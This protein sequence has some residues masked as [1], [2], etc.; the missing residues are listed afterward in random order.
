MGPEAHLHSSGWEQR[1]RLKRACDPDVIHTLTKL[2]QWGQRSHAS[3]YFHSP[4]WEQGRRLKRVCDQDDTHA[5]KKLAH[6]V[7]DVRKCPYD[8]ATQAGSSSGNSSVQV[9][10]TL[11]GGT[12]EAGPSDTYV[13]GHH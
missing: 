13:V 11:G 8:T 9:T 5:Q 10:Q 2:V 4:G 12:S 7:Q 1:R 3:A 6:R